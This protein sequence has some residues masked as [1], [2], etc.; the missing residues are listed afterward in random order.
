[1]NRIS[2][3]ILILCIAGSSA[4]RVQAEQI[5]DMDGDGQINTTEAVIALRVAA[6]LSPGVPLGNYALAGVPKTGQTTCYVS[7]GV[8]VACAN[9]GQD[10]ELQRGVT[11]P[12]PRF[13]DNSDG[14]I[15]DNMT[16]LI[17]LKNANCIN[18]RI[19]GFDDDDIGGDGKVTRAHALIFVAGLNN[20]TM[21]DD[22]GS[23]FHTDCGD[24][25]NGGSAQSDWRLPNR[26]ELESI[27]DLGQVGPCLPSG[28]SF[29]N[30]ALDYYWS[31][32]FN[33]YYTSLG[34][35]WTVHFSAG[36]V[37]TRSWALQPSHVWP[38]RGGE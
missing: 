15:I 26:F 3:V 9:T 38:V 14:T 33:S 25:S 37:E 13:T 20:G 16:G 35:G 2:T 24:I 28:H 18:S 4:I 7:P 19:P 23:I 36:D 8:L 27:L 29:N 17:W 32:S 5:G 31:S 12:S 34:T 22:T 11:P 30:V 21:A 1:M 6:G 10:G